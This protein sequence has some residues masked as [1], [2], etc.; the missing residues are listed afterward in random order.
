MTLAGCS[1]LAKPPRRPGTANSEPRVQGDSGQV[2]RDQVIQ[3]EGDGLARRARATGT[4]TTGSSLRDRL[5]AGTPAE[6]RLAPRRGAGQRVATGEEACSA[7]RAALPPSSSGVQERAVRPPAVPREAPPRRADSRREHSLERRLP[8]PERARRASA[9]ADRAARPTR[10]ASGGQTLE[11]AEGGG[12]RRRTGATASGGS[13]APSRADGGVA[14][15][16][17]GVAAPGEADLLADD[18]GA[19]RRAEHGRT[20]GL[21]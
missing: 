13:G 9:P 18:V 10:S 1:T 7:P 5:G 19:R 3:R 12:A 6:I 16:G 17:G 8:A 14:L 4:P 20:V 21:R 11:L 2:C 15:G